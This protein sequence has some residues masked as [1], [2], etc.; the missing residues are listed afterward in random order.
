METLKLIGAWIAF[1]LLLAF[2]LFMGYAEVIV[3]WRFITGE[4]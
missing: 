4:Y 1:G 3:A 2:V